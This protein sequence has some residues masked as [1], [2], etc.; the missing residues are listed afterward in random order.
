MIAE[1]IDFEVKR[2]LKRHDYGSYKNVEIIKGIMKTSM[3]KVDS[4]SIFYIQTVEMKSIK[5]EHLI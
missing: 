1:H 3:T 4:T 2:L 5:Y